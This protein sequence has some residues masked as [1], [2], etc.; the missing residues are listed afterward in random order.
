MRIYIRF[1]VHPPVCPRPNIISAAC[2]NHENTVIWHTT[3]NSASTIVLS[4]YV[5]CTFTAPDNW[6]PDWVKFWQPFQ[7]HIKYTCVEI[8]KGMGCIVHPLQHHSAWS[9]TLT[10]T[11]CTIVAYQLHT[12]RWV[13][14]NFHKAKAWNYQLHWTQPSP[15]KVKWTQSIAN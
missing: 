12:S 2:I 3:L 6:P 1:V 14:G 10:C 13:K 8:P 7:H 11:V 9:R 4:T 5:I 15:E